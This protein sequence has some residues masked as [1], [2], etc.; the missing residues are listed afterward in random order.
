MALHLENYIKARGV[1]K[2][3]TSQVSDSPRPIPMESDLDQGIKR[4][5]NLWAMTSDMDNDITGKR[6][7]HRGAT[8]YGAAASGHLSC[9]NNPKIRGISTKVLIPMYPYLSERRLVFMSDFIPKDEEIVD[10][11]FIDYRINDNQIIT[12]LK[13]ENFGVDEI[14]IDEDP[15]TATML[16]NFKPV[17]VEEIQHVYFDGIQYRIKLIILQKGVVIGETECSVDDWGRP[18]FYYRKFGVSSGEIWIKSKAEEKVKEI[19]LKNRG[20]IP[21]RKE[22]HYLGKSQDGTLFV[23]KYLGVIEQASP[24]GINQRE[25]EYLKEMFHI[26]PGQ[27]MVILFVVS[28]LAPVM[29]SL[30][31]AERKNPEFITFLQAESGARKTTIASL[32]YCYNAIGKVPISFESTFA[33]IDQ[34]LKEFRDHVLPIDDLHP[35]PSKSAKTE[36]RAKL[37]LLVRSA[38]DNGS[39]RQKMRGGSVTADRMGGLVVVTG[40][41]VPDFSISSD[42]RV[43]KVLFSKEEVDTDALTKAQ[44]EI[45]LYQEIHKKWL[46][47]IMTDKEMPELLYLEADQ[48]NIEYQT[49]F[50][51]LHPRVCAIYGWIYAAFGYF[52]H[53]CGCSE[54]CSD[55]LQ[56]EVCQLY[57]FILEE[58]KEEERKE[59]EMNGP[60]K[61]LRLLME[62]KEAGKVIFVPIREKMTGSLAGKAD[63]A[64]L[65]YDSDYVYLRTD[66][67]VQYIRAYDPE[68]EISANKLRLMLE[69]DGCLRRYDGNLTANKQISGKRYRVS[70]VKKE[71]L[72]EFYGFKVED[73]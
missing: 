62:L 15:E 45:S 60:Q 22:F 32:L 26:L 4:N 55:N 53:F 19:T 28:L 65:F 7:P 52:A 29:S 63:K 13:E 39:T 71:V 69:S 40:E 2:Y 30:T 61:Y 9:G 23:S 56:E 5:G 42:A 8:L 1:Q 64:A 27:K 12:Q 16:A 66:R 70:P 51:G 20:N 67:I 46:Q 3:L 38:G 37:E 73:N 34:K 58:L 41:F 54:E 17:V 47:L 33:G 44:A 49:M 6:Y 11:Q 43:L 59:K 68:C 35:E 31:E 10:D 50:P 72:E 24:E 25:L 57:E 21:S 14:W 36:Q 48:R 18:G